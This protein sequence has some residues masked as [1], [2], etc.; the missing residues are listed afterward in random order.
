M[1]LMHQTFSQ[2]YVGVMP[3]A[4]TS[5]KASFSIDSFSKVAKSC[6]VIKQIFSQATYKSK[7]HYIIVYVLPQ[8]VQA[9]VDSFL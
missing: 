6:T 4:E 2:Q 9:I 7:M 8:A 1:C 3:E 5:Q